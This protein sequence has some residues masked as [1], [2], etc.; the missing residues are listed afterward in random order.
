VSRVVSPVSRKIQGQRARNESVV[1][2]SAIGDFAASNF[3]SKTFPISITRG[4][5]SWLH[6]MQF[7]FLSRFP[8]SVSPS[9]AP[10]AASSFARN[11][12]SYRRSLATSLFH[13]A[14]VL[15]HH[16]SRSMKMNGSRVYFAPPR[17]RCHPREP[18]T[19]F[20]FT[21]KSRICHV[22][23]PARAYMHASSFSSHPVTLCNACQA[24]RSENA[25]DRHVHC[26][27]VDLIL[28]W[29][30]L[31]RKIRF[32]GKSVT[33]SGNSALRSQRRLIH[34]ALY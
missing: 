2:K 12:S 20:H 31:R 30:A 5:V 8:L 1:S 26:S 15:H 24:S 6:W 9:A 32:S 29:F 22:F 7:N 33:R 16:P 3:E 19:P 11:L 10:R 27:P 17:Y 28:P 13:Q 23:P 34:E 14:D 25:R 21:G 4:S 18:L